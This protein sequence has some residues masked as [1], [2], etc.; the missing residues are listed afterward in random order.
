VVGELLTG[1]AAGSRRAENEAHLDEFLADPVVEELP[2]DHEVA[3]IYSEIVTAL[4]NA[5]APLPTNDVW[6]AATAAR[7]GAPLVTFD[8]HFREIQRI[9][10]ILLDPAD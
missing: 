7:A 10:T 4:R 3:P 2:V 8:R 6:I 9:G 1:F 5:G